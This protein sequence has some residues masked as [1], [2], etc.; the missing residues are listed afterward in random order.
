MGHDE[1]HLGFV[2]SMGSSV[3]GVQVV[4]YVPGKF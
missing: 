2:K 4:D 1:A 3:A